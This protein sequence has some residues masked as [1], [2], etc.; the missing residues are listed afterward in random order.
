MN[1]RE[2]LTARLDEDEAAIRALPIWVADRWEPWRSKH[3][4]QVLAALKPGLPPPPQIDYSVP[5]DA[6]D[7]EW[8][9][10][11]GHIATFGFENAPVT[12]FIARHDPAR[13]LR[14]I[15]AKRAL[16]AALDGN[17]QFH[18]NDDRGVSA[19]RDAVD[20]CL[21]HLAAPY[22]NDPDYD[23]AWKCAPAWKPGCDEDDDD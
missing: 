20:V 13:A 3:D 5:D 15:A 1:I 14:E 4:M 18:D 6:Y 10:Y 2:F 22:A 7:A 9:V 21:R 19:A 16:I 8:I 11:W 12:R 23:P 17:V